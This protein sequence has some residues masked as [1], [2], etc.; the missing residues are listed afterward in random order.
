MTNIDERNALI[1]ICHQLYERHL[2]SGLAGNVS[3]R[4]SKNRFLAT[5]TAIR[6]SELQPKDLI[7]LN[8]LGEVINGNSRPSSEMAMHYAIYHARKDANAIVHAHPI[9]ATIVGLKEIKWAFRVTA[10]GIAG[11]GPVLRT[12]YLCPGTK[13]LAQI[14]GKAAKLGKVIL[15]QHHGACT[16]GKTLEEAFSRMDTLEHV[17]QIALKANMFTDPKILSV[18]SANILRNLMGEKGSLEI[19]DVTWQ[20]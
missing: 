1:R 20:S 13:E 8:S 12:P 6:K 17:S 4:V 18:K 2:L 15:L 9:Y 5:P 10:E 3:L 19:Q 14:V 11:L 7:L 16:F